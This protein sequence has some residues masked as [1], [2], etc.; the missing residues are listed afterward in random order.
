[1]ISI[2][3]WP[4]LILFLIFISHKDNFFYKLLTRKYIFQLASSSIRPIAKVF[5]LM[6]RICLHIPLILQN[7]YSLHAPDFRRL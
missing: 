5:I 2:C 4:G 6:K 3:S 7:N 1:M